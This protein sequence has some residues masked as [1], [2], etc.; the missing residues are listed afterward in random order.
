MPI[1]SSCAW[2]QHEKWNSAGG[3]SRPTK[4]AIP[5]TQ[6]CHTWNL[7]CLLGR[8]R[9]FRS[10]FTCP[11]VEDA[12]SRVSYLS[13]SVQSPY[14]KAFA[15]MMCLS[16]MAIVWCGIIQVTVHIWKSMIGCLCS[17]TLL[18]AQIPLLGWRITGFIMHG[19]QFKWNKVLKGWYSP[20]RGW[21]GAWLLTCYARLIKGCLPGWT[22]NR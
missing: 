17:L 21:A 20:C 3:L 13:A 15:T 14:Q 11:A 2:L 9:N 1:T 19:G 16:C 7:T 10:R 4:F 22:A 18:P 12:V 8:R 5:T 6:S